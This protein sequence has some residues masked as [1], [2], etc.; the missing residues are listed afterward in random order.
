MSRNMHRCLKQITYVTF[1]EKT[2][3]N[4]LLIIQSVKFHLVVVYKLLGMSLLSV[5]L[6]LFLH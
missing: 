3:L 2:Q 1:C 4:F 5:L 6:V